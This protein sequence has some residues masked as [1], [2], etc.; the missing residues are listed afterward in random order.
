MARGLGQAVVGELDGLRQARLELAQTLGRARVEG[1]PERAQV[2]FRKARMVEHPQPDRLEGG[3]RV[4]A[5]VVLELAQRHIGVEAAGVDVGGA[6]AEAGH[7]G[8]QSA[9][10]KQRQRTP[11]GVARLQEVARAGDL[12]PLS[13]ERIVADHAPLG[14]RRRARRVHDQCQVVGRHPL[15]QLA[16]PLERHRAGPSLER[17][18]G[19]EAGRLSRA[20]EYDDRPEL[21]RIVKLERL[22]EQVREVEELGHAVGRE[23]DREVGVGGHVAQ[24]ARLEALVDGD[25]RGAGP[26]D[27]DQRRDEVHARIQQHADLVARLS[28]RGDDEAGELVGPSVELTERDRFAREGNDRVG[29]LRGAPAHDAPKRVGCRVSDAHE[30]LSMRMMALVLGRRTAHTA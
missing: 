15:L 6:G 27:P 1:D 26:S 7:Q 28:A 13:R 16:H 18:G 30:L 9:V 22:L 19:D 10:V 12:A 21:R 29:P 11:E 2:G 3:D 5:A 17:R 24:L 8:G 25:D 23:H 20:T 4:R 14:H